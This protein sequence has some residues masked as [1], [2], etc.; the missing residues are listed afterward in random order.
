MKMNHFLEAFIGCLLFFTQSTLFSQQEE[1]ALF[2]KKLADITEKYAQ[3]A[4]SAIIEYNLI[5]NNKT[6]QN[7]SEKTGLTLLALGREYSMKK[8]DIANAMPYFNHASQIADKT[9][10][11][12]LKIL[13]IINL[14]YGYFLMKKLDTFFQLYEQAASL[15]EQC[16]K[17]K[18]GPYIHT[19]LG[20][21]YAAQGDSVR[22]EKHLLKADSLIQR[23]PETEDMYKFF[24]Y[25]YL[26]EFYK[27][28][29]DRTKTMYYAQKVKQV[30]LDKMQK[31]KSVTLFTYSNF[32]DIFTT[33]NELDSALYY[34][35]LL[36]NKSTQNLFLAEKMA[37][38]IADNQLSELYAQKGDYK[39]A[40]FYKNKYALHLD[41][42]SNSHQT[43]AISGTTEAL[44]NQL[45]LEKKQL[46]IERENLKFYIVSLLAA[47][48][49]IV[50]GILFF[51]FRKL[52]QINRFLESQRLELTAL[53]DIRTKMFSVLS[54]DLVSPLGALQNMVELHDKG[55]LSQ[56]DFKDYTSDI[57]YHVSALLK[58]IKSI[59]DWSFTQLDGKKPFIEPLDIQKIVTEQLDLQRETARQKNI[60]LN[61]HVPENFKISADF[62]QMSLIIRNLLDNALKY[63]PEGGKIEINA[64]DTE[65][66]KILAFKDTGIGMSAEIAQN[67][68]NFNHKDKR[69][70]SSENK[71]GGLGLQ[72]VDDLLKGNNCTIS[73]E[74]KENEGSV[75]SLVF[76]N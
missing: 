41:S 61:N 32:V 39:K 68:F 23:H 34:A 16:P 28:K 9:G 14:N 73:V 48:I 57:K 69:T 13:A 36:A 75:F 30:S 71:D 52:K 22:G 7:D 21:N 50:L 25:N 1:Q 10:D 54:H 20:L 74:S 43:E 17:S 29:K 35:H 44:E 11:C 38:F 70:N 76:K 42:L 66:G 2:E 51:Y 27:G 5:L 31:D 64:S 8:H 33:I 59:L 26:I 65:G 19:Q 46:Q 37:I 63:T 3:N 24:A 12:N 6:I 60:Q 62:N 56:E 67:L 72:M 15:F 40:L 55:I 53:N 4:D 18:R 49:F 45:G 47:L 58:T